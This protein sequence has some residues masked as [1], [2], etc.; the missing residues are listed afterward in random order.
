MMVVGMHSIVVQGRAT[1]RSVR[2]VGG[3]RSLWEGCIGQY[4]G[5]RSLSWMMGL[6]RMVFIEGLLAEPSLKRG[7]LPGHWIGEVRDRS[8]A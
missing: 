5:S 7:S 4:R 6:T 3:S 1:G 8:T 2:G